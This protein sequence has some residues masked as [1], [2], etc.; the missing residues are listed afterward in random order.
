MISGADQ[1][2]QSF[3]A[4][5]DLARAAVIEEMSQATRTVSARQY[6][7]DLTVA[8]PVEPSQPLFRLASC[9]IAPAFETIRRSSS[10]L[11]HADPFHNRP[12]VV[13]F[14]GVGGTF[15]IAEPGPC[16]NMG[17]GRVAA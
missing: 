16:A 10:H 12:M 11:R 1:F 6:R 9:R 5:I 3:D 2:R 4:M 14:R 7:R 15:T 17:P 13:S 8:A